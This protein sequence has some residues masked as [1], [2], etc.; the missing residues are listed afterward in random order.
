MANVVAFD[1]DLRT[2]SAEAGEDLSSYQYCAVKWSSGQLVKCSSAGEY[3]VGI[4]QNKP[5]AA[6]QMAVVAYGGISRVKLS[7]SVS[8][9]NPLRTSASA[10]IVVATGSTDFLLG[11]ALSDG[12]TGERIPVM[13][14]LAQ[15]Y[16]T[17][18]ARGYIIRGS[19]GGVQEAYDANNS[20]YILIG[21]GTDIAS[22]AV[23]GDVGLGATG[24]VSL[25]KKNIQT[26]TTLFATALVKASNATPLVL[27]NHATLVA[28]GTIASGDALI[29]HGAIL[30]IDGGTANFDNNQNFIAKYQ[31]AG[32]GATVSTTLANFMNAGADAKLS[33]L[34]PLATDIVPEVDQDIVLTSSASPYT[35]AGDRALNVKTFWSAYTPV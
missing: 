3:A 32:G 10:T 20:G 25:N 6:G 5:S 12:S 13:L 14:G 34:K 21:N 8:Q 16:G 24:T 33:T 18:L 35:A 30:Q 4:L 15:G 29:F 17:S 28:A 2:F 9:G 27:L 23:S 7:G 26:S 19:S 11:Y 22:C 31:T 1:S